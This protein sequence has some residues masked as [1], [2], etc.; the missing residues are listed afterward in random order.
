MIYYQTTASIVIH[1]YILCP[2]VV[3]VN[4]CISMHNEFYR[5]HVK[6]CVRGERERERDGN[7]IGG[8]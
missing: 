3:I 8:M 1:N 7:G 4:S 5:Q 2:K 6:K